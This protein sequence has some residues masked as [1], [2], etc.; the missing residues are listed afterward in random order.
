[1]FPNAVLRSKS[2]II[3]ELHLQKRRV[4]SELGAALAANSVP[5]SLRAIGKW[6]GGVCGLSISAPLDVFLLAHGL[7]PIAT[8][9]TSTATISIGGIVGDRLEKTVN[10]RHIEATEKAA[11]LAEKNR[12]VEVCVSADR[13]AARLA[14]LDAGS[15][16]SQQEQRL[17]LRREEWEQGLITTSRFDAIIADIFSLY[18]AASGETVEEPGKRHRRKKP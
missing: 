4:D 9:A 7:P 2:S 14:L 5:P 8:A 13:V 16:R 10:N 3:E 15:L 6:V 11:A 1:M 12:R 17:R 18:L